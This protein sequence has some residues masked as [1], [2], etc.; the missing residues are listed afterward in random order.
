MKTEKMY[1]T[2]REE[3]EKYL[4]NHPDFN[5]QLSELLEEEIYLT[6][7]D[8]DHKWVMQED[9]DVPAFGIIFDEFFDDINVRTSTYWYEDFPPMF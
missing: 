6:E 4:E 7:C 2:T 1:C 8:K 5:Q 3:F 9:D